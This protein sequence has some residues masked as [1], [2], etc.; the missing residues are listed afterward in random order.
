[1]LVNIF[2]II[3]LLNPIGGFYSVN[4]NFFNL[5]TEKEVL[6]PTKINPQN[7]GVEITAEKYVALDVKSGKILL[8]K[9]AET[10]QPIASIT[11]LMTALVLLDFVEKWDEKVILLPE[12]ETIGARPHIYR[13]EEVLFS[14]LWNASL[15]S[16]DNNS[17]MAMIRYLNFSRNEF[18]EKMNQKATELKMYNSSFA[19]P[20]GLS[21]ENKSTALDIARL[22]YFA[23]EREEIQKAVVKKSFTFRPENSKKSR[24]IYNTDIL[25]DSFLNRKQFGYT[26]IGGKTGF[27]PQSGYCLIVEVSKGENS[28]IIA[29][30]NSATIESRFQDV[31][32]VADWIFNNYKWDYDSNDL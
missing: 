25:L 23:L 18:V 20:T 10:I 12:D 13:G 8:Q 5:G 14:D 27:I 17:I 3:L 26:L 15:I 22:L 21:V 28:V 2:L 32:V 24:T 4:G 9:E 29:V 31:K 30:L 6:P 19:D 11:K 16:S 1:M 7:I